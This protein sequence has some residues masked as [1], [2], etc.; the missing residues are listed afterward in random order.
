MILFWGTCVVVFLII[1]GISFGLTSLWFALGAIAAL[2]SAVLRAP[3][4][5][6]IIWFVLISGTTL[7]ATRPL[8]R[9]YVN[10]RR[11]ATNADRVIGNIAKVTT[12]IDNGASS[13]AVFID[14]K[15]WTARSAEGVKIEKDQMVSVVRIE[16]V[17]LIV[18]ASS[19]AEHA[20][21]KDEQTEASLPE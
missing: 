4:W 17:K 14:G 6:Q 7:I 20:S 9:K 1:E 3:L 21:V 16:G 10:S 11:Q 8:A 19:G 12:A 5:L 15:Y 18:Q 13:G 2:I